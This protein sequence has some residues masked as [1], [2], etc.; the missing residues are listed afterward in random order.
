[1]ANFS[2]ALPSRQW[3]GRTSHPIG[4]NMPTAVYP[5]P[6]AL[7][8]TDLSWKRRWGALLG[9]EGRAL[10][11]SISVLLPSIITSL[12]T[13]SLAVST[14]GPLP[15]SSTLPEVHPGLTH[16]LGLCPCHPLRL[17]CTMCSGCSQSLALF[18][19]HPF[20][21]PLP[22]ILRPGKGHPPSCAPFPSPVSAP[23]S[24]LHCSFAH[25]RS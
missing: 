4:Y 9:R 16:P 7:T 20:L 5:L 19:R 6:P 22:A 12:I 14:A 3:G 24:L 13:P 15:V 11:A 10:S 17:R 25:L 23:H 1:M 18:A 8:P 2:V 21:N